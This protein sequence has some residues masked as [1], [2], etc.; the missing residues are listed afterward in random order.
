VILN[1]KITETIDEGEYIVIYRG[2]EIQD[3]KPVLVKTLKTDY[4]TL[5]DVARLRHEYEITKNLNIEGVV[6]SYGIEKY[7]N[8]LAIILEDFGA[9]T[10]KTRIASSKI[11]VVE[12][13][14][15]AIQLT[16]ILANLH[17][18]DVIHKDIKPSSIFINPDTTQVKLSNFGIASRLS[19]ENQQAISPSQLEGSLAY[20]SPEQ[21]GRMNRSIDYRTDFYSLGVTFYEMLTGRLPFQTTDPL[22]LVHS[23]IAKK[24]VPPCDINLKV[25]KSVSE[26]VMKLLSKTAE[27]RYQVAYGIKADLERCLDEIETK[28]EIDS[29]ELGKQDISNRLQ[30]PQKLYGR[31]QEIALLMSV[32]DRVSQEKSELMLVSGYSGIGKSAL[33]N[34]IHKPIVYKD[35]Y[36][37]S[38][39]FDQMKRNVPYNGISQA[40]QELTQQILTENEAGINIWREQ[41]LSSLGSNG[42]VIIDVIPELE[43]IIGKQPAIQQLGTTESQNRFNMTFQ[44]FMNVFATKEH[45]LVIFLD[46]LQ[47]ADSSSLKLIELLM[48]DSDSRYLL[49]IGA[50]RDNE[51]SAVHPLILMLE[52]IKK[53]AFPVS[54]INLYPLNIDHI[55]QF[56]A[57]TFQCKMELVK[58]MAELIL[59]KTDGNP[60]FMIEFLK[61]AY[62]NGML[63]FNQRQGC[64]EWDLGKIQNME[65]TGNVIELMTAKILKCSKQ[66]Q[67]ILTEAACIGNKF[68]LNTLSIIRQ[69]QP[70]KTAAQLWEALQVGLILPIGSE[71]KYLDIEYQ[72]NLAIQYK[73]LHDRVQ[74]AAYSMVPEDDK[75]KIHLRIGQLLLENTSEID[76]EYKIFEI[77]NHLNIAIKELLPDP[78]KRIELARLNLIAGQKAKASNFYEP[79]LRYFR[80]GVELLPENSWEDLPELTFSLYIGQVECEY[81]NGNFD[82]AREYFDTTIKNARTNLEKAT[83]Y[84]ISATL[85]INMSQYKEAVEAGLKGLKLVGISLPKAPRQITIIM[86]ILKAKKNLT[87]KKVHSYFFCRIYHV[88]Q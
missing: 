39:K 9:Q 62:Q 64:W 86:E 21:T 45:P 12:F 67:D 53:R 48:T 81:L 50:Y 54:H 5:I 13:L 1:Y 28:G 58:P 27:D 83:A 66:T 24:P 10:L 36:F 30:I 60:F 22:E 74:Q 41:F 23:H 78:N 33:V 43:L 8:G 47:W 57:D 68:D 34:E 69:E 70:D 59:E 3:N 6:K 51:V 35:G 2:F 65:A 82:I 42:Q 76:L 80:I 7:L 88:W 63:M 44:K 18:N 56:L 38:G 77:I 71:Y 73:F 17:Q 49:M 61:A 85:Y 29:F 84:N 72:T 11:N 40:F 19:W 26:I 75:V 32:F 16:E 79:A 37:I 20:M 55:I 31:D 15:I 52:N 87:K 25:C 4:P 46:D 14:K